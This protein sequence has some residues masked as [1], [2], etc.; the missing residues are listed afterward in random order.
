MGIW[1]DSVIVHSAQIS[2]N[3]KIFLSTKH[4][5]MLYALL[6]GDLVSGNAFLEYR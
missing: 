5:G 4:E 3:C 1:L 2:T 6:M